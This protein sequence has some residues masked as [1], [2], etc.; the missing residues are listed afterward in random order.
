MKQF[1][2]RFSKKS[3]RLILTILVVASMLGLLVIQVDWLKESINMQEVIFSK[4]VNMALQQTA[5]NMS[6]DEELTTAMQNSIEKDSL[7]NSQ[8][9]FTQNIIT[10][11]DSTIR[12]ELDF[13][14]INLDF[15][16]ILINGEDTLSLQPD[17]KVKN[18]ELFHQSFRSPYPDS[19]IDL[20]VHF[21]ERSTF[22]LRRI[23]IMFGISVVLILFTM[24]SI[25]LILAYS[26]RE[27]MFAQQ[28]KDMIGNLTH[29]FITP[30]SS[31]S[32]AG[33]MIHARS[34]RLGDQAIGQF[35]T[36]IKEEN[37]KLQRQV[38]RLLQLAAVENSGFEYNKARVDIHQIIEDA[39]HSM[40]FL[41]NQNDVQIIRTF[42][43]EKSMILA[44]SLHLVDVFVNLISNSIKYSVE[45][46]F[47][48]IETR[49]LEH[50]IEI[51]ITDKGI[52]IPHREFKRIFE[53]YYRITTGDLHNTKGFGIGLYYVKTVIRAHKGTITVKSEPAKGSTF[54]ISLPVLR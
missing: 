30:I 23:G 46:P 3:G 27:R 14:H 34:E 33:N 49:N 22:I 19:S 1:N 51:I 16:F 52:G 39:L 6:K 36:A 24:V 40:S 10:R 18:G 5:L 26:R 53:K 42:Q 12:K 15:H 21:P 11:L 17:S 43:A 41:L 48:G 38:D 2:F 32:L 8:E 35:A 9:V 20:A 37:K 31:I 13:Y 25:F 4:G 29:E 28:V 54:T 7:I 44:D 45:K 47:I 50:T